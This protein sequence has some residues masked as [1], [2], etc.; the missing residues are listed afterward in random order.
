MAQTTWE[1]LPDL[2]AL[3]TTF[4]QKQLAYAMSYQ[5]EVACA[6]SY[7]PGNLNVRLALDTTPRAP[8]ETSEAY[9]SLVFHVIGDERVPGLD[10]LGYEVPVRF[11]IRGLDESVALYEFEKIVGPGTTTRD[12]KKTS[13]TDDGAAKPARQKSSDGVAKPDRRATKEGSAEGDTAA[14]ETRVDESESGELSYGIIN[15]RMVLFS[16]ENR[17]DGEQLSISVTY[18]GMLQPKETITTTTFDPADGK[19]VLRAFVIP[20]FETRHPKYH[21]LTESACLA[22]GTWELAN[23]VVKATFDVYLAR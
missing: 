5:Y 3:R 22:F 15:G 12:A 16:D 17:I 1:T 20:F 11:G 19:M 14:V 8:P 23:G 18:D 6:S 13:N 4:L 7:M 2:R 21:W 10:G 9:G